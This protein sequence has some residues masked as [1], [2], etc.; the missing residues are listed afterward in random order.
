MG[1]IRTS[2]VFSLPE[3]RAARWA[4][5]TP[6][7]A[8]VALFAVLVIFLHAS[9]LPVLGAFGLVLTSWARW[10]SI[11]YQISHAESGLKSPGFLL[12]APTSE[13]DPLSYEQVP[14]APPPRVFSA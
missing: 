6:V 12:L 10:F 4:A 14:P 2:V 7:V 8:A 1:K 13:I 3:A 11:D 9:L 5:I